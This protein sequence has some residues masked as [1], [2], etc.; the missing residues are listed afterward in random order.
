MTLG[1]TH[2]RGDEVL[3][4]VLTGHQ[5]IALRRR[6]P[7]LVIEVR[8]VSE[9]TFGLGAVRVS[10]S[11]QPFSSWAVSWPVLSEVG[12]YAPAGDSAI[13]ELRAMLVEIVGRAL[14]D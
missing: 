13:Y 14:K 12:G 3:N 9:V 1:P 8:S 10:V 5:R 4:T 6:F 2:R 11:R 7:G